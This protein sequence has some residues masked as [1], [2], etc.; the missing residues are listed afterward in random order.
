M[1]PA[2][3][4]QPRQDF[5]LAELRALLAFL[6][7][8][9]RARRL[10][11]DRSHPVLRT[12]LMLLLTMALVVLISFPLDHYMSQV[13][14][15]SERPPTRWFLVF[16]LL[17]APLLE[18][19]IFRAGL[20][21]ARFTLGVGLPLL[22]FWADDRWV[23]ATMALAALGAWLYT[24]LHSPPGAAFARGRHYL[25]RYPWVFWTWTAGFACAHVTNFATEGWSSLYVIGFLTPQWMAGAIL[26]Y[27]RL[28]QGLLAAM[29]M[30]GLYNAIL[31]FVPPL[32]G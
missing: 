4:A 6:A 7:R 27:L 10:A 25:R 31:T 1:P 28:R 29:A 17:V 18:E 15:I 16:A 26:G 20:R 24:L 32:S 19:L 2:S 23:L 14:G 5:V 13:P 30:H 3:Q 12:G 11:R 21:S 22:I 9:T 8:P